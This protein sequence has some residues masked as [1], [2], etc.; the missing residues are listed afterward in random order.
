MESQLENLKIF[1]IIEKPF[2]SE[3]IKSIVKEAL[4]PLK[5]KNRIGS[6]SEAS[7]G[8]ENEPK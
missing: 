3:Q 8:A 6:R 4:V 5:Y 2:K 1:S 7:N